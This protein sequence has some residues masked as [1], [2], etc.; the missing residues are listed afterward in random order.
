MEI[1]IFQL[2]IAAAAGALLLG[3]VMAYA[4]FQ[5]RRARR[6]ETPGDK[7]EREI[8]TRENYGK[9]EKGKH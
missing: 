7:I 8:V 9:T 4:I 1:A 2:P 3:A 5:W 6:E